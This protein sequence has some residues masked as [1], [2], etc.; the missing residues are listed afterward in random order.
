M[1]IVKKLEWFRPYI[2][3]IEHLVP[4]IKKLKRISAKSGDKYRWQHAHGIISYFNDKSFRMTFYTTYHNM[5]IDKI[6]PYSTI[7]LLQY[8]AHELAH[9]EHWEHTT[10]HKH[11]EVTIMSIF[12]TRLA[13]DG[14]ISEE[15]EEKNGMFYRAR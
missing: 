7:D 5:V 4:K 10:S 14:Y 11:L 9:L 1:I 15:D 6:Q 13:Q 3:S 12:M 2:K 8:L